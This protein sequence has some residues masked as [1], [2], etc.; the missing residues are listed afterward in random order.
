MDVEI[1]HGLTIARVD[2]DE[3]LS[4]DWAGG[5][6]GIDLVRVVD[7][8]R[9]SWPAL[10]KIGFAINP[11][12]IV[13]LAPV[14]ASEDAFLSRLSRKERWNVRAE[15]R[16]VAERGV[17]IKVATPLDAQAFDAFLELYDRQV[18]AM[19]RG[20]P[21]ARLERAEILDH[22][23]DY[24]GIQALVDNT[25]VGGCVCRV[26]RDVSTV[27]IRFATT[28]PDSRQHRVVRAMYMQ[29]FQVA[30]ELT[31][32]TVSLGTDPALYGHL[33]KPGLFSFKSALRFTPIPA[34]LF[35]SMDDPDEATRVLRMD[36]LTDPAL[37]LC[38]HLP[39]N[40]GD[41]EVTADTPL[42]LE[43]LTRSPDTDL[44]PFGAPFLADV[45]LRRF[46]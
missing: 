19:R 11:A 36:G 22:C 40:T 46:G 14:G 18:G 27:V 28:T 9:R 20:V 13:W 29:V 41:E 1:A 3:A 8:E 37:L 12:W 33:A 45:A 23:T 15:Q 38:Y 5:G 2:A 26:R 25:L 43:V 35:G 16:F 24:F 17:Q 44:R 10:Q 34:R 31:C 30:R 6:D 32:G 21:F 42:R 39:A 4:R 7:P